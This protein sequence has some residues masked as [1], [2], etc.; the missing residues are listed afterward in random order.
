MRTSR[1]IN[2]PS[3]QLEA[4]HLYFVSFEATLRQELNI[5][6]PLCARHGNKLRQ[7]CTW[8]A[9]QQLARV[10]PKGVGVV[11]KGPDDDRGEG[12]GDFGQAND[13]GG[14]ASFHSV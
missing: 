14:E 7:R 8:S 13:E 10:G 9:A 4:R 12:L 3:S 11:P 6:V 1:Y 2:D 5:E